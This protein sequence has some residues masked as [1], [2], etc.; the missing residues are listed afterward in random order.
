M[1]H[2]HSPPDRLLF[3]I[4]HSIVLEANLE[5]FRDV[6]NLLD[7]SSF[8]S[9]H[10]PSASGFS[11]IVSCVVSFL[12]SPLTSVFFSLQRSQQISLKY[13]WIL[14]TSFHQHQPQ[15]NMNYLPY[16]LYNPLRF[17]VS[18]FLTKVWTCF[19]PALDPSLCPVSVTKDINTL[20]LHTW[21][22]TLPNKLCL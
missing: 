12:S 19:P 18:S 22:S 9:A 7:S 6:R 13:L 10:S 8:I 5:C 17:T 14:S 1:T 16:G 2:E 20:D 15:A 3:W 11:Q 4:P 21:V